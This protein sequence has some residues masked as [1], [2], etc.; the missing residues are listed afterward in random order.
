M[1]LRAYDGTIGH[2][3][4]QNL[5]SRKHTVAFSAVHSTE[6]E[7]HISLLRFPPD[8]WLNLA[9]RIHPHEWKYLADLYRA[10]WKPVRTTSLG[11]G[12]CESWSYDLGRP[13]SFNSSNVGDR[14]ERN[15]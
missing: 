12:A 8:L 1:S 13:R 11:E 9:P 5:M 6:Y 7:R 14:A 4:L 2:F 10:V 3:Q 15:Y